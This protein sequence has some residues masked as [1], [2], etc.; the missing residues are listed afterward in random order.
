MRI[1]MTDDVA[2]RARLC[3][4]CKAGLVSLAGSAV[5]CRRHDRD[6][7]ARHGALPVRLRPEVPLLLQCQTARLQEFGNPLPRRRCVVDTE[8]ERLAGE[9]DDGSCV[10]HEE[11]PRLADLGREV[12]ERDGCN[13]PRN[14]DQRLSYTDGSDEGQRWRRSGRFT[15][16]PSRPRSPWPP[17]GARRRSTSWPGITASTRRSSTPGRSNYSPVLGQ[18]S[19]TVPSRPW[20]APRP[21]KQSCTSRSGGS[22]WNWSG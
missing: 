14:L 1:Q 9:T 3:E 8:L 20:Q 4:F 16:R 7:E 13:G 21:A 5:P 10:A 18:S 2:R 15:R 19:P 12:V 22:R 17:S 6:G 11:R